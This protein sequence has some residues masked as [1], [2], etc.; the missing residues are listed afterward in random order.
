MSGLFYLDMDKIPGLRFMIQIG[1][2]GGNWTRV[3]QSSAIG[4]TCLDPPIDLNA[5]GPAV[6]AMSVEPSK[7]FRLLALNMPQD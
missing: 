1:G 5:L 2:D 7:R 3:R 6:G 4:S